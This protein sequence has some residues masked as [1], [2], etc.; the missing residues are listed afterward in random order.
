[1]IITIKFEKF[2]ISNRKLFNNCNNN[3]PNN[4]YN[5][6]NLSLKI[7]NEDIKFN[8]INNNKI[9]SKKW[10]PFAFNNIINKS[11]LNQKFDNKSNFEQN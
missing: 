9:I 10:I 4:K 2:N 6:F 5:I 7:F 1:M 11:D 3:N 8:N